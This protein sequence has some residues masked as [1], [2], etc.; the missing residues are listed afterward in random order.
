MLMELSYPKYPGFS[1]VLTFE[2]SNAPQAPEF[3]TNRVVLT[4]EL[5]DAPGFAPGFL[6]NRVVLS[7]GPQAPGVLELY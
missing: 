5:S 2:L 7:N 3:L 4:F 1:V 6:T